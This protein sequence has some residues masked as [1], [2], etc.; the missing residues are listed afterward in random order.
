MA[1]GGFQDV[2]RLNRS[3]GAAGEEAVQEALGMP[4]AVA[5]PGGVAIGGAPGSVGE[6]SP[7][8][9]DEPIVNALT[10]LPSR[11]QAAQYTGTNP[12]FYGVQ[13]PGDFQ[14]VVQR[15]MAADQLPGGMRQLSD[16]IEQRIAA[17]RARHPGG[18]VQV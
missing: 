4:G 5:V 10:K 12:S 13:R 15:E 18:P 14:R 9:Y 11:D 1:G 2:R 7:N 6:T 17:E 16:L 8:Y 3:R